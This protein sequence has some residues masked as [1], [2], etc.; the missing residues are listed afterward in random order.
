MPLSPTPEALRILNIQSTN[1]SQ[2]FPSI[3]TQ[4]TQGICESTFD[5]GFLKSL[6]GVDGDVRQ[7][8]ENGQLK[9][10]ATF[11]KGMPEGHFHA[12]YPNGADA[13]KGHIENGKKVG[14]H[15]AFFPGKPESTRS[16]K[17]RILSYNLKGQLNGSQMTSY[18]RGNLKA[19]AVY[20]DGVLDGQV[21]TLDP[22]GRYT[23]DL[24]FKKGNV[25]KKKP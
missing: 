22:Q 20:S 2:D 15:I 14:I 3:L 9:F 18:S 5:K 23:E 17:G 11:I 25:L 21:Q 7:Y 19:F 24:L 10:K 12:Y 13:F 6:N 4:L 8:W 16:K 1:P